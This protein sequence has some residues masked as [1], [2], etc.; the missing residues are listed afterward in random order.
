MNLYCDICDSARGIHSECGEKLLKFN[1]MA[2]LDYNCTELH[3]G[4]Y[5]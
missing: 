4:I 3:G 1:F 5:Q 2:G